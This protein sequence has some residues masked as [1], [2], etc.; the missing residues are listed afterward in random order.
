M[1]SLPL[2]LCILAW[3]GFMGAFYHACKPKER[4]FPHLT[5]GGKR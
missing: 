4:R 2:V 5:K 1:T 3:I